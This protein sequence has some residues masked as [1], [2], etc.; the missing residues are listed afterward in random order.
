M[1]TKTREFISSLKPAIPITERKC[2]MSQSIVQ[3][4]ICICTNFALQICIEA[5]A[6][7]REKNGHEKETWSE[8]EIFLLI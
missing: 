3:I 5:L 4:C 6:L 8:K 2:N 7:K 1:T